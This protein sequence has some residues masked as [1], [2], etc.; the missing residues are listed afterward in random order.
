[1]MRIL[2]IGILA[3][4]TAFGAIA[5]N[6]T[7]AVRTAAEALKDGETLRLE[8]RTYHLFAEGAK[9]VDCAPTGNTSGTKDVA[10]PL[11]GKKNVTID[12]NGAEI[13]VHSGVFPFAAL[14]CDGVK[15]R[16]FTMKAFIPPCKGARI[17]KRTQDGVF[18]ELDEKGPG[19]SVKNGEIT[20]QLEDHE[21]STAEKMHLNFHSTERM[22]IHTL[23]TRQPTKERMDANPASFWN[24]TF[25]EVGKNKLFLRNYKGLDHIRHHAESPYREGERVTLLLDRSGRAVDSIF[26]DECRDAVVE[27]VRLMSGVGMGVV[28]QMCHNVTLRHYDVIPEPGSVVSLTADCVYLAD[29]TGKLDISRCEIARALD[30]TINVKC[31]MTWLEQ[32]GSD[33]VMLE[34]FLSQHDGDFPYRVGEEVEFFRGRGKNRQSLGIVKVK[35]FTRPAVTSHWGK[36]TFDRVIPAEWSKSMA[37]SRSHAPEVFIR[38]C[39]FH[40]G[41]HVRISGFAKY[42]MERNRFERIEAAVLCEDLTGFWGEGGAPQSFLIRDNDLIDMRGRSAFVFSVPIRDG[43]TMYD[44]R[45]NGVKN[46]V[47]PG[48]GNVIYSSPYGRMNPPASCEIF[49]IPP[50][51]VT[52]FTVHTGIDDPFSILH[53]SDSHL[54]RIDS[55]DGEA[56]HDFAKSRSRNGRELGE[57]YLDQAI[58]YARGKGMPIIHTGDF[59][60]FSSFAN[61]ENACRRLKTENILAVVGNHEYW[62]A[63]DGGMVYDEMYRENDENPLKYWFVG[64]PCE[65]RLMHGVNFL[66]FDDAI[67]RIAPEVVEKFDRLVAEQRPIVLVCHVPPCQKWCGRDRIC[68]EDP[69]K[70][71][72][73]TRSFVEKVRREP[74][75]KAV[76]CGHMHTMS[77]SG[78]APV[79]MQY[80]AGALFRGCAQEIRFVK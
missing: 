3:G 28:A 25:E 9:K 37:I 62:M 4:S 65:S 42:T 30:D 54:V 38:D 19:Y 43:I 23:F 56:L 32:G 61:R 80:T 44:N 34:S 8:K 77:A 14:G 11:L 2:I 70:A 35:E 22:A 48:E 49:R 36:V 39:Y 72:S 6:D 15:L 51:Q 69:D 63:K 59:M 79:A 10:F 73:I 74:L 75:V 58:E 1:M 46:K 60:E 50:L 52:N 67:G 33:T 20:F 24:A 13:I 17:G 68:G 21:Y 16:N 57:Y 27:N 78:I 64:L 76:L 66:F 55:R 12:G 5:A 29:N 71:D 18:V 45:F 53:V 47:D 41:F 26:F 40:D 7:P 31:D